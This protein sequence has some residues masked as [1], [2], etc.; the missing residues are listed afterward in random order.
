MINSYDDE[1]DDDDDHD[2]DEYD[3]FSYSERKSTCGTGCF[4]FS[5]TQMIYF[6]YR[7]VTKSI[8]FC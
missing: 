5:E 8:K 1:D 2:H 6:H 7:K 3:E 4:R